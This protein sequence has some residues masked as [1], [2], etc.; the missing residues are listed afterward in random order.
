VALRPAEVHAQ[1]HLRPVRRLGAAGARA[2]RQD[3]V[4][5]VVLAGEQEQRPLSLELGAQGVRLPLDIR[6][7]VGVRGVLEQAQQLDQVVGALLERPPQRDL[8]AQAFSL[9][10]GLLCDALVVPEAW[11]AGTRVQLGYTGFLDDEVKDAPRSPGSARPGR[12]WTLRPLA[13]HPE[14]LEQDRTELDQPQGRLAPGDDG[15]HAGTVAVVGADAAI[16]IAVQRGGVAAGPAVPFAR[17]QIDELGFLSLLHSSLSL[18]LRCR[19]G[20]TVRDVGAGC[21]GGADDGQRR[22]LVA[23]N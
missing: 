11:I 10:K 12:G 1:Q 15:V 2:D 5:R 22:S 4:L 9:A 7:G 14:I 23:K 3:G 13:P 18:A 20:V 21:V 6:L 19:S 16:A 8:I 17:D